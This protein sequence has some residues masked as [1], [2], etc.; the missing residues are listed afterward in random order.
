[1]ELSIIS[2]VLSHPQ[3]LAQCSEW[4]SENLPNAIPL[5]TNS[6]SEAVNMV[7]VVNLEQLLVQNH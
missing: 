3:A 7:K 4:L 5:P 6:T 1:M 2:E